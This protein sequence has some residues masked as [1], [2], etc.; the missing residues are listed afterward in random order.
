MSDSEFLD[1]VKDIF[2][3]HRAI[4]CN[5]TA[6]QKTATKGAR[7][8]VTLP[9]G[10]GGSDRIEILLRSRGGRWIEKWQDIRTLADFRVKTIPLGHPLYHDQRI[11]FDYEPELWTGRLNEAHDYW[12]ENRR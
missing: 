2:P 5:L 1:I 9:N 11:W 12:Q 3:E 7:A 4:Q 6:G 10:G 8:Y